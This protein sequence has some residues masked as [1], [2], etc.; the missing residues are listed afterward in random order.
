MTPTDLHEQKTDDEGRALAVADLSV[1]QRVG[2]HH[3]KQTLLAHA[4]LLLEEVVLRVRP[5]DIP[6]DRL[7]AEVNRGQPGS[8]EVSGEQRMVSWG[9]GVAEV[10]QGQRR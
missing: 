7:R 3:V 4:V 8:T 6:P 9:Q 10:G 1:M 2:L 5:R